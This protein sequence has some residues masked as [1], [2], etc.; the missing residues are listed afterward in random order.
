MRLW[1][2]SV[3]S[4]E[5]GLRG[6]EFLLT[7][8]YASIQVMCAIAGLISLRGTSAEDPQILRRTV[9]DMIRVMKHRG[10]DGEGIWI[11]ADNSVAF[12]HRRL[13]IVDLSDRG[14]QPMGYGG[15]RYTI[16]FNGEIYNFRELARELTSLGHKFDSSCD[17]EVILAACA[18]WG[19]DKAL[20]RLRGMF[21]FALWD[22]RDRTLHL[23][24][25]RIGEKP[26]H[27]YEHAGYLYFASEIRSFEVI[28]GFP[29]TLSRQGISG[30][31][32]RGYLPG[33]L[34]IYDGVR[35][36]LP[37]HKL[38]LRIGG[39]SG[40]ATGVPKS[41]GYWSV[42]ESANGRQSQRESEPGALAELEQA[43]L[44][45]VRM[46]MMS[47]V[48][49]GAF[50]SGGIDSS[51]VVALAQSMAE[52]PTHTFTVA[53]DTPGF[54]EAAYAR[55]IATRLG[56]VHE[57][58]V[59]GEREIVA[60][61]P[62][63]I[64]ALD[65]PTANASFFATFLISELARSRVKVILS[66]DGGDELFAG[67]SR[68]QSLQRLWRKLQLVPLSARGTLLDIANR[69]GLE[70]LGYAGAAGL[71]R[72]GSRGQTS[73]S[74]TLRKLLRI[75]GAQSFAEAYDRV[76]SCWVDHAGLGAEIP[77]QLPWS[78]AVGSPL[79]QML[80]SDQTEYLPG[81]SLAKVDRASMAAS[82]ETRA[83]LLDYRVIEASWRLTDG[84]KVAGTATKSPLR[85][86]LQRYIP[87]ALIDRKKMGF[88][89]PVD[90][91]LR[92]PLR[93]WAHDVLSST[94]FLARVP[95]DSE[96]VRGLW[97]K[98]QQERGPSGY[99]MWSLVILAA[100]TNSRGSLPAHR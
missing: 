98:Y 72:L 70:S 17:T 97:D 6:I 28:P 38:T 62:S 11:S 19:F 20:E 50:L 91:W 75:A 15:G 34:S 36:L 30:Y 2:H 53:F 73:R 71:D 51:T 1:R 85:G 96:C 32:R 27:L 78:E 41:S 31:L 89:V 80:F 99:E 60:R 86:I 65:E 77:R 90:A 33:D 87:N 35:K 93:Q 14:A 88:T 29:R 42:A 21:A 12:A 8:L 43:L 44:E 5:A 26:L 58:F 54:N 25:D 55:E 23:A 24:R 95:L 9:T 48:P 67:Y 57:E 18:Q 37:G 3:Q 4:V 56:T 64:G 81:D 61:I 40:A 63:L 68:Y 49:M 84:Q 10:P 82:L 83:P 100:W 94:D 22:A 39:E 52:T 13:A 69:S 16:T 59:L 46:Q 92:G 76:T 66:G 45:S 47:D 7:S 74:S 79:A